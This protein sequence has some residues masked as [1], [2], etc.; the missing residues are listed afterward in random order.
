MKKLLSYVLAIYLMISILPVGALSITASAET[1]GD[2]TYT[3][4]NN[5]VAIT[6]CSTFATVVH[7]PSELEGYPVTRIYGSAFINCTEVTHVYIP[8]SVTIIES[9]TFAWINLKGIHVDENNPNYCSDDGVLFNKD[10][11]SLLRVPET[12]TEYVV[13]NSVTIIDN[14]AFQGCSKLR[15][16]TIRDNVTSIGNSAF[17]DCTNLVGIKIPDSVKTIGS[18]AFYNCGNLNT[19]DFGNSVTTIGDYAFNYCSSLTTISLPDSVSDIN[20]AFNYCYGLISIDIGDG[21]NMIKSGAFFCCDKLSSITIGSG[22]THI[23]SGAFGG[24]ESLINVY[25]RGTEEQWNNVI[26]GDDNYYLTDRATIH[27]IHDCQWDE[28]TITKDPSCV[29]G[30]KTYTCIW[31]GCGKIMTESIKEVIDHAYGSWTSINDKSHQRTCTCGTVETGCHN[32]DKT[33]CT[34]IRTCTVCGVEGQGHVWIEGS[35]VAPKTCIICNSTEGDPVHNVV[36]DICSV[37]NRYGICGSDLIWQLDDAGKLTISGSGAMSDYSYNTI[38]WY[39]FKDSVKTLLIDQGVTSVGECAFYQCYGLTSVSLPTTVTIIGENAF[40]SCT[41]LTDIIIPNSV[42]TIGGYAFRLCNS[43]TNIKLP[44]SVSTIGTSAFSYCLG[45]E[46]INIPD[47]VATINQST[48]RDSKKLKHVTIG[49]GVTKIMSSAFEA[50]SSIESIN[51][52]TTVTSIQPTAFEGCE[53]LST[54][55]YCGTATQWEAIQFIEYNEVLLDCQRIQHNWVNATCTT[56]KTCA[57]C[58]EIDGDVSEHIYDNACDSTCN[59]CELTR[60]PAD[61]VYDNDCDTTCNI[62]GAVTYIHGDVNGDGVL[63]T[64]DAREV[65]RYI[66]CVEIFT[67]EQVKLADYNQDEKITTADAR[68]ILRAVITQ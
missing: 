3:I 37:C 48:F 32:W 16:V 51:I 38:P 42:T 67:D 23:V 24:C 2:L 31:P 53:K 49:K 56:P 15:N 20:R 6:R 7:I 62:C 28:G 60:I 9:G 17:S 46:S 8:G 19:V 10:K 65:L 43:I 18:S 33:I 61:H 58:G 59:I 64:T 22:V 11:T 21:V 4:V 35:C 39:A 26:I 13:P 47:S 41:Q 54:V 44:D 5:E 34:E 27:Y 55:I 40:Y 50:C 63:N 57:F 66:V 30:V 45:L 68:E 29:P 25:Y 52:P 1:Y 12:L 14:Y 36:G